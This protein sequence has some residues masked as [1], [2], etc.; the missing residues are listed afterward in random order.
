VFDVQTVAQIAEITVGTQ[1][2]AIGIVPDGTRAYVANTGSND[3]SVI[4]TNPTS[5]TYHTVLET[6]PV[7]TAPVDIEVSPIGPTVYVLN[8][9]AGTL[10]GID[11][12][13]GN[14]TFDQ[15]T[16]TVNTGTGTTT[17]KIRPDGSTMY[18]TNSVGFEVVNL[19]SGQITNTVSLGSPGIS[20]DVTPDGSLALVLT[21]AGD[22]KAVILS[23]GTQQYQ[24]VTTVNT[25]TG[26]TS[27]KIRPDGTLAYVT[28]GDGNTVLA[29]QITIT[30]VS[31]VSTAPPRQVTLTLV[32]T[33]QVGQYPT[34]LA[35][36]PSGRPL[37]FVVN[38]ASGT[39]TLIGVPEG[40]PPADVLFVL[41]PCDI[42]LKSKCRWVPA[43]I[44]PIA[45]YT[46]NQI[47]L[48]SIR[49][50]GTVAVDTCGPSSLGDVNHDGIPDL[51]VSFPRRDLLKTL[52]ST[53]PM[54]VVATGSFTDL[55]QFVGRDT[56][57]MRRG[58][59][60]R[61][62]AGTNLTP[63]SMAQLTWVTPPNSPVQWVAVLHSFDHGEC[64]ELDDDLKPNTGSYSWQVPNVSADS[65]LVAVELVESSQPAPPGSGTPSLMTAG[66]VAMSQYFRVYGIT[67]VDDAPTTLSFAR[68]MPNPAFGRV[69]MRFGIP[70][71]THVTLAV[72]DLMGRRVR[73]LVDGN[74]A[75][76]WYDLS[77][78]GDLDSGQ[79]AASGLYFVRFEAQG[80]VF[81]ERLSWLR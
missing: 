44:Q 42:D 20:I 56:L 62:V 48:N 46:A 33:I 24:V 32:A 15:V 69:S 45:P 21:Q 78:N 66:T 61:P 40:L 77:W 5:P 10:Q 59:V 9:G 1:P 16:S 67:A 57:K 12:R 35:F 25:G 47:V 41:N 58:D 43:L 27:V 29:F 37:G 65:V 80:R 49:L 75:P 68:P 7:D 31:A 4:D 34:A 64:W 36:D 73:T 17:I 28:N 8:Q 81:R 18:V 50:N 2:Q 38:T 19:G 6:I 3:V 60:D 22:L 53:E 54:I 23:P 11:A 79:R 63:G 39:I 51:I 26:S 70:K 74:R 76:G 30:N 71:R 13:K 72:F 14:A 55:R 52:P